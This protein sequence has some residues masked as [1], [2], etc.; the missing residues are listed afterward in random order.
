MTRVLICGASLWLIVAATPSLAGGP[1][2]A[3]PTAPRLRPPPPPRR[4]NVPDLQGC[5]KWC[6]RDLNPCDPPLFKRADGR[7]KIFD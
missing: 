1:K 3:P 7:C 4:P 6:E 5:V 2:G